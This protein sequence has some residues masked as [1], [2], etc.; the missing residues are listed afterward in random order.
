MVQ[1]ESH[2]VYRAAGRR[3]LTLKGACSA[4]ARKRLSDAMESNGDE[5]DADWYRPRH[6]R[7]TAL[8]LRTYLAQ[9]SKPTGATP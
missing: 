1:A 8:Y 6:R 5:W 9:Q 4:A 7:L 2:T 3:W